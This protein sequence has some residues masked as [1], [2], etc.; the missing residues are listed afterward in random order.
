MGDSPTRSMALG[1]STLSYV[2][3]TTGSLVGQ[4]EL[5]HQNAL[6]V[7]LGLDSTSPVDFGMGVLL[8][9]DFM[10]GPVGLHAGGG[11]GFGAV[12]GSTAT[13]SVFFNVVGLGGVHFRM[14]GAVPIEVLLD[15]GAIFSAASSGINLKIGA[16]SSQLGI[17][18][19]YHL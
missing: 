10:D 8:R 16:L 18:V 14:P 17:S 12:A 5:G 4:F 3:G 11:V 2:T 6:L 7:H 1:I 13:N 19:L 15:G 9:H